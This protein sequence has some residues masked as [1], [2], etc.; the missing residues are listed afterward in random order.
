ML[1]LLVIPIAPMLAPLELHHHALYAAAAAIFPLL[2]PACCQFC[3]G[4]ANAMMH[5]LVE[6]RVSF[7]NA[8][9]LEAE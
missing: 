8:A 1:A 4:L 9:I 2:S 6:F 7:G 3:A 5:A